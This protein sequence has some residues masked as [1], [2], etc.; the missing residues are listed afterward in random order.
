M[1]GKACIC[2]EGGGMRYARSLCVC[3]MMSFPWPAVVE[4]LGGM[5]LEHGMV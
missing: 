2:N 1:S 4:S 5:A 3:D